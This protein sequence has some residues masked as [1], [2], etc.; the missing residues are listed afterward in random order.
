MKGSASALICRASLTGSA[1]PGVRR[2]ALANC[3]ARALDRHG[4][5]EALSF[6]GE[7]DSDDVPLLVNS[8]TPRVAWIRRGIRLDFVIGDSADDALCDR[9]FESV[10]AAD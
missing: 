2:L 3:D 10:W 1:P 5:V 4:E 9:S 6:P 8:W 7:K